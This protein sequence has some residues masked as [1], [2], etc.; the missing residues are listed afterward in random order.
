MSMEEIA[1]EI[2]YANAD[3]VKT[4]KYKCILRLRK[5]MEEQKR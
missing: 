3:T 2:G 5:L 1:S 4:Q